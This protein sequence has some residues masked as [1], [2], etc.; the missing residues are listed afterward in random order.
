MTLECSVCAAF[1]RWLEEKEGTAERLGLLV[2]L[3]FL[4]GYVKEKGF[5][6]IFSLDFTRNPRRMERMLGTLEFRRYLDQWVSRQ[7]LEDHIA[8]ELRWKKWEQLMQASAFYVRFLKSYRK[9]SMMARQKKGRRPVSAD[10]E[11]EAVGRETIRSLAFWLHIP[12]SSMKKLALSL[13]SDR[14]KGGG[15][16]E[17]WEFLPF[18]RLVQ[19]KIFDIMDMK[20]EMTFVDMEKEW[21][22][23]SL[24]RNR[25]EEV[26]S[27][28]R[29]K[30]LV[31]CGKQGYV[32]TCFDQTD[33][34]PTARCFLESMS[35]ERY[36]M[37]LSMR[38]DGCSL[39]TIGERLYITRERVRQIAAR[40][41]EKR[42]H[43]AEDELAPE[44]Q[45][46]RA[47]GPL[48]FRFLFNVPQ[49]TVNYL[50]AVYGRGVLLPPRERQMLLKEIEDGKA[51]APLVRERAR[52]LIL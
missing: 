47:L 19:L 38:L 6:G 20:G 26:I 40:I 13:P 8:E 16:D 27:F 12:L 51:F 14:E 10:R 11:P 5:D 17:L 1:H 25:L 52:C 4:D 44:W 15:L 2:E 32:R 46:Y 30:G 31:E 49:C 29:E 3:S 39:K 45:K 50:S 9:H 43:L 42:P 48:Y 36:R 18:R 21:K 37:I 34:Y 33:S 7:N 22:N 23:A 41:F 24:P 28:L 35:N